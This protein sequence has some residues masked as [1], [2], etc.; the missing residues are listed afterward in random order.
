MK[1]Y[2]VSLDFITSNYV[3]TSQLTTALC[4]SKFEIDCKSTKVG[5]RWRVKSKLAQTAPLPEHLHILSTELPLPNN[6]E[7]IKKTYLVVGVLYDSVT[8]SVN[9]PYEYLDII[10]S[11]YKGLQ[12]EIST[13]P[14]VFSIEED[15]KR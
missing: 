13:Y 10:A 1:E 8:C 3:S 11:K 14:T 15:N 4:L 7:I 12:V 6:F 5:L 2:L 9:F